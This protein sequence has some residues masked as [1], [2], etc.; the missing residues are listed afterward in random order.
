[1]ILLKNGSVLLDQTWSCKDILVAAGQ[2]VAIEDQLDAAAFGIGVDVIDC[3]GKKIVPGFIDGHVHFTGGG[4]EGGFKTRTPEL[5]ASE[6]IQAGVTTVVGCLGTDG[7]TRSMEGL[8]AKMYAL[9]EEGV[10]AY[11]YTGSYRLPLKTVTGDI[12]KDLLMIEGIIGIGEIAIS[13]HRSAHAG[14]NAFHRAVS[15]ARVG[16]I[17]SGKCGICNVHLG[18]G[19]KKFDPIWQMLKET[20]IPITQVLPTHANRN[21]A[22]FEEAIQFAQKGG[23]VDFT[24]STTP[25]FIAEGEVPAAKALKVM[26]ESGVSIAQITMTSDGHG[27]L[28]QFDKSGNIIGLTVGSL[29]SLFDSVREAVFTHDIPLEVALLTITQNPARI[30]RLSGKGTLG[31]GMDADIVILSSDLEI[32]GVLAKGTLAF[33]QGDMLFKDTF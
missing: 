5:K 7:I 32:E 12:I 2:C 27:S 21:Q 26:L 4:G 18:D 16:G 28:P 11:C 17:L 9:R 13:D 14:Q 20:D 31:V 30:L 6:M 22:V 19:H 33:H 1:M 23:N 24:T 25:L 3:D 8:V 15:D 29:Q 10:S